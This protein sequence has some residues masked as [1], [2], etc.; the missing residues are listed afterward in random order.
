[1]S[2]K[3]QAPINSTNVTNLTDPASDC[4]LYTS[5]L[6]AVP[7]GVVKFKE[8]HHYFWPYCE[9]GMSPHSGQKCPWEGRPDLPPFVPT[10]LEPNFGNH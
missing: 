7:D 5:W 9:N 2:G 3:N 1:M 6:D 10:K 4:D 8:C